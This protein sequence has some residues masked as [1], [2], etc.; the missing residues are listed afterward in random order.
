MFA[1]LEP[2]VTF[3]DKT[4]S[5]FRDNNHNICFDY[6]RSE[7][8]SSITPTSE[9][10]PFTRQPYGF[11]PDIYKSSTLT[12]PR[13]IFQTIS[14]PISN[15]SKLSHEEPITKGLSLDQVETSDPIHNINYHMPHWKYHAFTPLQ[16]ENFI[17]KYFPERLALYKSYK[18]DQQKTNLFV[19][20][21]LYVNGGVYLAS[22]YELVKSI[23]PVLEE[24]NN[25]IRYDSI[26]D[27]THSPDLY[28]VF[29]YDRFISTHFIAS[30]PFCEFWIELV[31]L[32][33]KRKN[34]HYPT[35]EQ[36]IDHNTGRK[37]LTELVEQTH[38]KYDII[39]RML[40]NPYNPCDKT[41][42]KDSYLRPLS[43]NLDFMTY[44]KCQTG[45]SDE[46]LYITG[47]VIIIIVIMVIIAL[48]TH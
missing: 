28:F 13:Q 29:D 48:I 16:Q 32:M 1:S 47:A 9:F 12:I 44:I 14:D 43:H 35:A 15:K 22:N 24:S 26:L 2:L 6:N 46:L 3:V 37:L 7:D 45:S 4:K 27:S 42:N 25:K 8:L 5:N 34:H 33:D 40:M 21:W 36:E 11:N 38:Y 31:N 30:L 39:P 20:L 10:T 17:A 18:Y 23:E 41:F 19:Y